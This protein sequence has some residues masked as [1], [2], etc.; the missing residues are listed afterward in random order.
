[1]QMEQVVQGEKREKNRT[2]ELLGWQAR[3]D[4]LLRK[5]RGLMNDTEGTAATL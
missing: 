1:M 2:S 5:M 3:K 4:E